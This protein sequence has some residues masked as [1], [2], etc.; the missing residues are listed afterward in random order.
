M[1]RWLNDSSSGLA[2][3][4]SNAGAPATINRTRGE[5]ART[6]F[7]PSPS[8]APAAPAQPR[9]ARQVQFDDDDLDVP[10]FLK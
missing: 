2:N 6:T 8:E 1:S 5:P 10:D 7:A 9:Q 4:S 3:A